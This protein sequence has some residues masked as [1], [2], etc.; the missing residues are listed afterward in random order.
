VVLHHLLSRAPPE[1]ASPHARA[2]LSLKA[3]AAWLDSASEADVWRGVKGVLDARPP[4]A[5]VDDV[6]GALA[7]AGKRAEV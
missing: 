3:Y 6:C 5:P 2:G 1:L 4:G 7:A